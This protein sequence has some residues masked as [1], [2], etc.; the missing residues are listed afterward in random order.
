MDVKVELD[1]NL[2]TSEVKCLGIILDDKLTWKAQVHTLRKKAYGGLSKLKHFC[3]VSPTGLK[4]KRNIILVLPHLK[5]SSMVW[6]ECSVELRTMLEIVQNFG[7]WLILL[8]PPRTPS[9]GLR[10]ILHAV[11][12]T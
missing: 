7:M 5:Y 6:Q 3:N 4:L 2:L 10:S 11:E 8:K 12:D 9:D 1:G